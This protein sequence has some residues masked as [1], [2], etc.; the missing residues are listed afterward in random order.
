MQ[1]SL[2][3]EVF[4]LFNKRA[5]CDKA[6]RLPRRDAPSTMRK[7]LDNCVRASLRLYHEMFWSRPGA[8]PWPAQT[9]ERCV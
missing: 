3:A 8:V 6:S 9:K 5:D 2:A 7:M 1:A 4:S